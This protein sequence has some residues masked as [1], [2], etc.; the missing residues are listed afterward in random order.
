MRNGSSLKTWQQ[1]LEGE[2]I[3][4]DLSDKLSTYVVLDEAG[5]VRSEG[6]VVMTRRGLER[7]FAGR[8]PA[9]IAI[10]VGTHSVWVDRE[11]KRL[12]HEVIVANPRAIPLINRNKKKT[13]RED[14]ETLARLARLDPKLLRPIQHRGH[15]AQADL[16]ILRSRDVLV[17]ARTAMINHVRGAVKADGAR[18]DA[19]SA[20]AFAA[21]AKTQLPEMLHQALLPLLQTIELMTHQLKE[22]R[23]QLEKLAAERYPETAGLRQIK[24][25]G[26]LTSLGFVLVLEDW[27]RFSKSRSVGAFVGLTTRQYQ[28]GESDPQLRITK[29]GDELLRRLLV[30]SGQYVLGPFGPDC[31]LR[32]WGLKLAGAGKNKIRKHKAVVAVARKLACLLHHLW[33]T[34]EVYEP[35]R[36]EPVAEVA[37]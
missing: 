34:G 15:Q 5:E 24:G 31:D 1:S 25:V 14:A 10:E 32:R 23:A 19:C 4:F 28:S 21:K 3:G 8:G 17:R 2:T 11:L 33:A 7:I 35:L 26:L 36:S 16:A 18:I 13:D 27:Q 37:A 30:Q 29:S 6:K 9:R 22:Y 12:G 20:D